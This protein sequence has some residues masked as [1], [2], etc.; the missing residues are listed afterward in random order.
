MDSAKNTGKNGWWKKSEKNIGKMKK[1][2]EKNWDWK[3]KGSEKVVEKMY[4]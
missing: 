1:N 4:S 2:W 3:K